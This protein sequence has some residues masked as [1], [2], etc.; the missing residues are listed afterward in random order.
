MR[1]EYRR[2]QEVIVK[3]LIDAVLQDPVAALHGKSAAADALIAQ[4]AAALPLIQ[5]VLNGAW[6]S[7]AHGKDVLEAFMLIASRI[8][9]RS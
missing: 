8:R 9:A 1:E 2:S 5:D 4:G 6:K 3:Q 7:E